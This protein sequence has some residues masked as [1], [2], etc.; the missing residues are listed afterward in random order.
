MATTS[1]DTY[2]R[3]NR[4]VDESDNNDN[5][6]DDDDISYSDD[7]VAGL[8]MPTARD[9]MNRAPR[10]DASTMSEARFFSE[11]FGT[12]LV[13]V[14]ILW[15]L[16]D[17]HG[18]QPEDGRPKHLLWALHFMKAYPLQATGCATVGGSGGAVDAKTYRKRVWA[19]IKAVSLL[20]HKVVRILSLFI[21]CILLNTVS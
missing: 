6:G 9:I 10:K 15:D 14:E 19:Y 12:R 16:L 20:V 18:L 13:I 8:F 3:T 7:D 17:Y 1:Q 2:S 4:E 21:Y 11:T 5:E